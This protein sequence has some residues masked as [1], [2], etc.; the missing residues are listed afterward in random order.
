MVITVGYYSPFRKNQ[1]ATSFKEIMYARERATLPKKE[2]S[3][4]TEE[5]QT[6]V[7]EGDKG[8]GN[9]VQPEESPSLPNRIQIVEQKNNC[10]NEEDHFILEEQ[11]DTP[12]FV[13]QLLYMAENAYYNKEI[14]SESPGAWKLYKKYT[15]PGTSFTAYVYRK[16]YYTEIESELYD[17]TFSFRGTADTLDYIEDVLQVVGNVGGLQAEDAVNYM[18]NLISKDAKLIHNVYFT[19]HSLG[20]YLAQW[21]QSEI[22]DQSLFQSNNTFTITFNAPGLSPF[23]F[24]V[25]SPYQAKVMGKIIRDKVKKYDNYIHNYRIKQDSISLWGDNL[26]K[27]YSYSAKGLGDIGYYHNLDRFKELSLT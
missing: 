4:D 16:R 8:S 13:N 24:P 2:F 10:Q 11:S 6:S 14:D 3:N 20:G 15:N 18:R 12:S 21:V 26:G 17:Y 7:Q 23:I 25:I 27:V 9:Q 19:G 22:I 1:N 5:S